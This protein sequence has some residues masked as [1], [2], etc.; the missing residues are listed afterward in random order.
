[1]EFSPS[2]AHAGQLAEHLGWD[3]IIVQ[4]ENGF[5][6]PIMRKE[7]EKFIDR[8]LISQGTKG[9]KQNAGLYFNLLRSL[10][11]NNPKKWD[12]CLPQAEFTFNNM[13][14]IST[15]CA[16]FIEA[17]GHRPN[18][19]MD[20]SLVPSKQPVVEDLITH[21]QEVYKNVK[22]ALQKSNDKYKT[23][24]HKSIRV[25]NFDVG[26]MV[27]VHLSKEW[28]PAGSCSKLKARNNRSF[29]I[30]RKTNSNAYVVDLPTELN[31]SPTFNVNVLR[32]YLHL[33]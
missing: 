5:Y 33:M 7:I 9:T 22:Q 10:V 27:M 30:L 2:D 17:Y 20:I 23:H 15:G 16:P 32:R 18:H 25:Q 8:F 24:V 1:M 4:L 19:V 28:Y 21:N 29:E 6:W 11:G 3:K 26:D 31:M 14:N 12:Q 13:S